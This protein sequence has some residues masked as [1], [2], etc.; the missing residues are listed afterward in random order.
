MP[1]VQGQTGT[2]GTTS[3]LQECIENCLAC[4]QICLQT[5][6]QCL[7]K[8]GEHAKPEHI[9]LL[10]DCAEICQTSASFMLRGS[11]NHTDI[12]RV[13]ADLCDECATECGRFGEEFMKRCADICQRCAE[14]CRKMAQIA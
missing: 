3:P 5:I 7:R 11:D 4:Y 8:G 1:N 13:C 9:R 6:E 14:S 10:S 2:T 12:C